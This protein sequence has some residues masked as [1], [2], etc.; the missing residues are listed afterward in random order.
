MPPNGEGA[1]PEADGECPSCW[2]TLASLTLN[3][4]WVCLSGD[5]QKAGRLTTMRPLLLAAGC[6]QCSWCMPSGISDACC[7]CRQPPSPGT[8]CVSCCCM[9]QQHGAQYR[10]LHPMAQIK[11]L[12]VPCCTHFFN[13]CRL[14][15]TSKLWC[16]VLDPLVPH[17]QRLLQAASN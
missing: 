10:H 11:P 16:P 4:F 5:F 8:H 6:N 15:C 3:C 13:C 9:P 1:W 2:I 14:H 17:L 12:T 7:H